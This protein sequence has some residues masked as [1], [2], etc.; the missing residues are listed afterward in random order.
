[1]PLHMTCHAQSSLKQVS[2]HLSQTS[3]SIAAEDGR[4]ASPRPIRQ[5]RRR[6]LAI[7]HGL[8]LS[9][10]RSISPAH[11]RC[12]LAL[13]APSL[14]PQGGPPGRMPAAT[15]PPTPA[16]PVLPPFCPARSPAWTPLAPPGRPN[17]SHHC[18]SVHSLVYVR[19]AHPH[20]ASLQQESKIPSAT[21]SAKTKIAHQRERGCSTCM[22]ASWA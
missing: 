22:A 21:S 16:G 5:R 15:C 18:S 1:M 2:Y 11:R 8:Q 13:E 20:T 12:P 3:S 6:P 14:A 7:V 17:D 10:K 4:A 19:Q 9:R